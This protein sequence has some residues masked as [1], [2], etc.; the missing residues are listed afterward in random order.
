M[1]TTP[2][3]DRILAEQTLVVISSILVLLWINIGNSKWNPEYNVMGL[4]SFI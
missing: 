2:I 1:E 4:F 3:K